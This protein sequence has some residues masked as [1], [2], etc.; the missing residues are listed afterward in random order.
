MNKTYAM[1]GI[2]LIL[3]GLFLAVLSY[4]VLG[5]VPLVAV[6]LSVIILGSTS[7]ALSKSRPKLSP[8]LCQI[9]YKTGVKNASAILRE[10]EIENRAIYLPRSARNGR[11]FALVPLNRDL[12][13]TTPGNLCLDF[14]RHELGSTPDEIQSAMLYIL[15]GVLDI[16]NGIKVDLTDS[17]LTVKV[18]GIQLPDQEIS[19]DEVLFTQ[20]FGSPIASIA[21]A[22]CCEAMDR[23]V[24][25][26]FETLQKG[27]ARITLE[28]LL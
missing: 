28:M 27:T 19:D 21:A 18:S 13:F 11:S 6:G 16:A 7:L 8:E 23:P 10:M 12:T 9:F 25:I 26:A 24:K 17:G 15:H 4:F 1:F 22:I 2:I 14:L 5:S 3:I 20:C